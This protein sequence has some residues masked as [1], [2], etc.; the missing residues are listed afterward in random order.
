[1]REQ[2]YLNVANLP[3]NPYRPCSHIKIFELPI[4]MNI[5]YNKEYSQGRGATMKCTNK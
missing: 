4:F 5:L 1:M 3:G 2:D